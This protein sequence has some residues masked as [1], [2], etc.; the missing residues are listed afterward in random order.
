[1]NLI[2]ELLQIDVHHPL[3]AFFQ[4]PCCFGYGRMTALPFLKAMAARMERRLV[5]RLHHQMHRLLP[6]V[7]TLAGLLRVDRSLQAVRRSAQAG[8][9]GDVLPP[10]PH[11]AHQVRVLR[12]WT[13]L[14]QTLL[15][16]F[17][18]SR[19]PRSSSPARLLSSC[20]W[21]SAPRYCWS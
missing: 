4:I 17:P 6:S 3:V 16:A 12:R 18:R 10:L 9:R 20:P 7:S 2:E 15:S 11:S 21:A 19:P 1:M 8:C 5:M 14:A 13:S